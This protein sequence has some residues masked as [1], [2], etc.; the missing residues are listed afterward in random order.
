MEGAALS[1]QHGE[2]SIEGAVLGGQHLGL[3]AHEPVSNASDK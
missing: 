2:G 1:G 3:E